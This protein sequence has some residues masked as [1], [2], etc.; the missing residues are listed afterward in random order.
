MPIIAESRSASASCL[1]DS[2]GGVDLI[3]GCGVAHLAPSRV[4]SETDAVP[5]PSAHHAE[6]PSKTPSKPVHTEWNPE[7]FFTLMG[8]SKMKRGMGLS[9]LQE[10]CSIAHY[11]NYG[12]YKDQQYV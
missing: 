2:E 10:D 8:D 11:E 4:I 12:A 6:G 9:T 7:E 3:S 1:T 5:S